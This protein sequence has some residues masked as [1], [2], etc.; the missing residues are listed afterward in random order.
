MPLGQKNSKRL[1][2]MHKSIQGRTPSRNAS[3][4]SLASSPASNFHLSLS[5]S[6]SL[7]TVIYF[8][9]QSEFFVLI[10]NW[11]F[12]GCL[13]PAIRARRR[14]RKTINGDDLLWTMA[15][16]GFDDYIEPL[17]IYLARYRE[18]LF[19]N[20][21]LLFLLFLYFQF[22]L[23][24]SIFQMEI[25]SFVGAFSGMLDFFKSAT[26]AEVIEQYD[27]CAFYFA[28]NLRQNAHNFCKAECAC[29]RC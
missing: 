13:A 21:Y 26:I 5:I 16:L 6:L 7:S 29:D 4:N 25:Y 12:L 14:K 3:P 24:F 11:G 9:F 17:R 20:F 8:A 15:I 28:R 23:H 18:V 10:L 27:S 1:K 2:G 22:T 19:F